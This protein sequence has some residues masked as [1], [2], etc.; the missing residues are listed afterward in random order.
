MSSLLS[1]ISNSKDWRLYRASKGPL[2][3]AWNAKALTH[4]NANVDTEAKYRTWISIASWNEEELSTLMQMCTVEQSTVKQNTVYGSQLWA[5]TRSYQRPLEVSDPITHH[6]SHHHSSLQN[7]SFHHRLFQQ[8]RQALK[9]CKGIFVTVF[10]S[11][12]SC[13]A[14]QLIGK[15]SWVVRTFNLEDT[16]SPTDN[17]H[18]TQ[19]SAINPNTKPNFLI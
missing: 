12:L 18:V 15:V 5:G 2:F 3:G 8:Y 1:Q 14:K 17:G 7:N 13:E 10:R 16:R 11:K 4:V 19:K 9:E 6:S